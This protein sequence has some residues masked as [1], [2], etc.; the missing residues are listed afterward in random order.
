MCYKFISF[1]EVRAVINLS[2]T[3]DDALF[4]IHSGSSAVEPPITSIISVCIEFLLCISEAVQR[5]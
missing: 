3:V 4:C 2:E 5:I 1:L